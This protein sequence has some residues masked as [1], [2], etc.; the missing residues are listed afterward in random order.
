MPTT[1]VFFPF[2]LFGSSGT[3][4]GVGVLEEALREVVADNRRETVPTRAQAY[5]GQLKVRRFVFE[6]LDDYQHWRRQ[7]RKVVRHALARGDFLIWLTGNHLG[8][9][10]VYEEVGAR[11]PDDLIIQFDAHLDIQHFG[12]CTEELSHGNFLLHAEEQLP[13]LV[14]IG[15]RDLLM[16]EDHITKTFQTT[17]STLELVQ[18]GKS[19]KTICQLA[20]TAGRVWIDIDC[21]VLDPLHFPAVAQP[22]PFGLAPLQLLAA[23]ETLWSERVAGVMLSEFAAGRDQNDQCL[24]TLIWLLEWMLLRKHEAR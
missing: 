18:N 13:R 15:H 22:V 14:N 16:P 19:W 8:V 10:P 9:L 21:D 5:M 12:D 7:G 23:L 2:D 24:A 4:D 6:T 1:L 11:H 17:C 20:E 3:A